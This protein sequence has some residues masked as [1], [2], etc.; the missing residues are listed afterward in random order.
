MN[1]NIVLCYDG[2]SNEFGQNN[3][4]IVKTFEFLQKNDK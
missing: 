1:K 2:T 4:N 3:T